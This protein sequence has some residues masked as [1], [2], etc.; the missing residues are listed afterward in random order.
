M[1]KMHGQRASSVSV[2]TKNERNLLWQKSVAIH[3]ATNQAV[4][5]AERKKTRASWQNQMF[6][7]T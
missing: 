1:G 4:K 2:N 3:P 6:F 7:L 5:A